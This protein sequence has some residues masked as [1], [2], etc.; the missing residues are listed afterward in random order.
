MNEAKGSV[1]KGGRQEGWLGTWLGG[2]DR[3][4]KVGQVTCANE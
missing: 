2:G 4:V 3:H 1:Q